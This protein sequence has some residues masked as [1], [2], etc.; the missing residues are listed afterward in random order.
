[1]TAIFLDVIFLDIFPSVCCALYAYLL[2]PKKLYQACKSS[3]NTSPDIQNTVISIIPCKIRS[4]LEICKSPVLWYSKIVYRIQFARELVK[5]VYFSC[6]LKKSSDLNYW[7]FL[8]HFRI[9]KSGST[10]G[11]SHLW[12]RQKWI[13]RGSRNR[14]DR[15][16]I[17]RSFVGGGITRIHGRSRFRWRRKAQLQRIRQNHDFQRRRLKS[18]KTHRNQLT[19][20]SSDTLSIN[21]LVN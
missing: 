5:V 1:M 21:W 9:G 11:I 17:G 6:I 3:S 20:T 4:S 15:S 16:S 19:I 10:R 8:L 2:I 12:Q 18:L 13:H 14:I 7:Q